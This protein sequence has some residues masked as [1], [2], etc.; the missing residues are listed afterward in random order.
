MTEPDRAPR[1]RPVPRGEMWIYADTD[2]LARDTA[3]RIAEVGRAAVAARGRFHLVLAGGTT[4]A[5][6][7][8]ELAALTP[9]AGV[10]WQHTEVF[11][12][13]ERNVPPGDPESNYRMVA[14]RLL[15]EVPVPADHVHRIA[16]ELPAEEAAER[17][18]AEIRRVLG[19]GPAEIPRFDLV[20]LGLAPDGHTASLFPGTEA[21]RERRHLVRAPWIVKLAGRRITMTPVA[22]NGSAQIWFLVTGGTKARALTDAVAPTRSSALPVHAIHPTDGELRW[23]VDA[24]AAV[25]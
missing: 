4:P 20:L 2:A 5:R 22:F 12:G 23:I 6:T 9:D 19:I 8:E 13:D 18:E 15:G 7:Y 16:G 24:A 17:Y 1:V 10:P 25:R 11:F 3:R 14:A 21:V